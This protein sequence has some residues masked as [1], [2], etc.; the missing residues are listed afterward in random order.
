MKKK[1]RK[2]S[3]DGKEGGKSIQK[4]EVGHRTNNTKFV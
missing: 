4:E 2:K 3:L 1:N